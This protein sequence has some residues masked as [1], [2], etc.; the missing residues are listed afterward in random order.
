[1]QGFAELVGGLS[2][3]DARFESQRC[4]SC[5]NCYECDGCLAA[6]PEDAVIKLGPGKRYRFD[7]DRCTG[8]AACFDQCPCSAIEMTPETPSRAEDSGDPR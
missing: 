3:K 6:C 7:Y 1:V 2:E 8:C 4:L 5:G